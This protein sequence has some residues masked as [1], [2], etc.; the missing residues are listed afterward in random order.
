[1]TTK[2]SDRAIDD[3]QRHNANV[4]HS[5]NSSGCPCCEQDHPIYQCSKFKQISVAERRN[6]VSQETMLQLFTIWPQFGKLQ[7]KQKGLFLQ[8][9]TSFT[10]A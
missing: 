8:K 4:Y 10:A 6:F 5:G 7:V 3:D 2:L 1:M 9:G